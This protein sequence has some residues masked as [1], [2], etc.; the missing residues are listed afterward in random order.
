[1]RCRAVKHRFPFI[2]N[3]RKGVKR[4]VGGGPLGGANVAWETVK[5]FSVSQLYTN[6][7]RRPLGDNQ[8]Y[9]VVPMTILTLCDPTLETQQR[10]LTNILG[11]KQMDS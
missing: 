8:S 4:G 3:G 1:M 7:Q 10:W 11:W 5:K 2:F 6:H 9:R